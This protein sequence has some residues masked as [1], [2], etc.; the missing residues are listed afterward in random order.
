MKTDYIRFKVSPYTL[1]RV[2]LA[3]DNNGIKN[4]FITSEDNELVV[5]LDK[6]EIEKRVYHIEDVIQVTG[7]KDEQESI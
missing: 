5:S 6:A 3:L 4:I 2:L 7:E 1:D